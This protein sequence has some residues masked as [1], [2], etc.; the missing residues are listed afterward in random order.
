MNPK[1]T[2]DVV[3]AI[4]INLDWQKLI[5]LGK[6]YSPLFWSLLETWLA[7]QNTV[8]LNENE[9]A[10]LAKKCNCDESSFVEFCSTLSPFLCKILCWL[11]DNF[12]KQSEPEIIAQQSEQIAQNEL[13]KSTQL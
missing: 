4:T 6:Q 13:P 10:S 7:H 12:T 2:T 1:A 11:I 9:L 5:N 8:T 3:K